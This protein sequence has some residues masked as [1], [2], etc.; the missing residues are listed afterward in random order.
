MFCSTAT[1]VASLQNSWSG[2]SPD[3]PDCAIYQNR[4]QDLLNE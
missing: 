3:T 1:T 2:R 4:K